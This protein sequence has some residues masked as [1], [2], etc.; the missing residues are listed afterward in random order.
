MNFETFVLFFF[1]LLIVLFKLPTSSE[2]YST[3]IFVVM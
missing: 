1:F 2:N 3:D